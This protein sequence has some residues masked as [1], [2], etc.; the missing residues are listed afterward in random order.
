[1]QS[2]LLVVVDMR[3]LVAEA[4]GMHIDMLEEQVGILEAVGR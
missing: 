1:M 3:S 2:A 4:E